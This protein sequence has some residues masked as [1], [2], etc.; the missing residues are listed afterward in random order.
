MKKYGFLLFFLLISG[1]S[2]S[3]SKPRVYDLNECIDIAVKNNYDLQLSEAQITTSA[4]GLRAAF[5]SYLPSVNF[6][7]GYDRVC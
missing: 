5:G 4:S 7:A 2:A 1:F 3:Y 6:S